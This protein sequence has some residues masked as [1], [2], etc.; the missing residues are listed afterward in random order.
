MYLWESPQSVFYHIYI[1][2]KGA[3]DGVPP[4]AYSLPYYFLY[5]LYSMPSY[6]VCY[7]IGYMW[8]CT[9]VGI[10]GAYRGLE[11]LIAIWVYYAINP[12]I[13]IDI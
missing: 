7:P 11:C 3:L 1:I 2:S 8:A 12:Y 5:T 6:A 9:H 10:Y 13:M 4:A